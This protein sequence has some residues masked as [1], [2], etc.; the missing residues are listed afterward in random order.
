MSISLSVLPYA[1]MLLCCAFASL[2]I[3]IGH[4]AIWRVSMLLLLAS[5]L[6]LYLTLRA[7]LSSVQHGLR[8]GEPNAVSGMAWH[9]AALPSF[10]RLSF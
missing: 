6:T 4:S 3:M 8:D 2:S 1:I 7:D 9:S 5:V 10:N